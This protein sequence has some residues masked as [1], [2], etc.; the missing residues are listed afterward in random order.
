MGSGYLDAFT[1]DEVVI[2]LDCLEEAMNN[3]LA[4]RCCQM[5]LLE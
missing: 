1:P 4:I 5:N 2:H 3:E